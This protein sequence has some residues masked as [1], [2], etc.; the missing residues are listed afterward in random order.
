MPY[1]ALF[2][3]ARRRAPRLS[4]VCGRRALA[5]LCTLFPCRPRQSLTFRYRGGLRNSPGERR[6]DAKRLDDLLKS[7]RDKAGLLEMRFDENGFLTLGD[8]TKFSGGSAT[9]RALLD[10]AATM[11]L[12]VDLESHLYSIKSPSP[13]WANP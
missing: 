10:A 6:L 11:T 8:Q 13:D 4:R 7:L 1:F 12:A 9:A 5:T 3:N 2:S